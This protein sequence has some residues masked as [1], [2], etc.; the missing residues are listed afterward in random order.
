MVVIYSFEWW[1][2]QCGGAVSLCIYMLVCTSVLFVYNNQENRVLDNRVSFF[3][4][5]IF[6]RGSSNDSMRW[7]VGD[8]NNCFLVVAM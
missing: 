3:F 7:N 1:L 6:G 2:Y 4:P 8:Y 5:L